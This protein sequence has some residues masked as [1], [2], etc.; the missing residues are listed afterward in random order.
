MII[1]VDLSY[2]AIIIVII[3]FYD[4]IH[5]HCLLTNQPTFFA[6]NPIKTEATNQI[7][8]FLLET[9]IFT[10]SLSLLQYDLYFVF[11]LLQLLG[12]I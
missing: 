2:F 1:D 11:A 6:R 9:L 8:K 12:P 3:N 7:S 10:F 4:S 5:Y